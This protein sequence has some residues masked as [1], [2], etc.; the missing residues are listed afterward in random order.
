MLII[1]PPSESKRP[2]AEHGPPVDLEALS[3]PELTPLRRRILDALIETS[4]R[5]DA[6]SDSA[7]GRR[8]RVRSPGTRG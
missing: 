8:R 2:P 5:P 6:F 7:S 3:F 1:V 4:A